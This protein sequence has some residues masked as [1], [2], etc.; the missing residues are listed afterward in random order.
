MLIVCFT[1]T[2]VEHYFHIAQYSC[3]L[4]VTQRVSLVEQELLTF[5]EHINSLIVG[6]VLFNLCFSV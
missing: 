5:P 1:C 6:L 2:G 4:T 3:H